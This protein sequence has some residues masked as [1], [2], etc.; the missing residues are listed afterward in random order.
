MVKALGPAGSVPVILK[1]AKLETVLDLSASPPT[2]DFGDI[3][4]DKETDEIVLVYAA[5][6]MVNNLNGLGTGSEVT[7][8]VSRDRDQQVVDPSDEDTMIY[9]H[10]VKSFVTNGMSIVAPNQMKSF[11]SQPLVT[12]RPQLRIVGVVTTAQWSSGRANVYLY[13]TTRRMDAEARRI[14]IGVE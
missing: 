5:D 10:I 1:V 8:V 3:Q 11:G 12:S 13:Y 9:W 7:V 4:F 14:L 2:T 6:L